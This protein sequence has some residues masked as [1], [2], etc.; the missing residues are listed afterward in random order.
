MS[1]TIINT[2]L[3]ESAQRATWKIGKDLKEKSNIKN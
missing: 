1:A 3:H 2:D